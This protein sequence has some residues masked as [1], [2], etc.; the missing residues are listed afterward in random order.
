MISFGTCDSGTCVVASATRSG[1]PVSIM[2][3]FPALTTSQQ[4][5]MAFEAI[6]GIAQEFLADGRRDKRGQ[7]TGKTPF[8][9]FNDPV[10]SISTPFRARVANDFIIE[11]F[12]EL[13]G[14]D[15]FDYDFRADAGRYKT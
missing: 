6:A 12:I 8:G 7:F 4:F 11:A 9:A 2:A 10:G 13:P 3:N 14:S 1:P 5:G 15:G